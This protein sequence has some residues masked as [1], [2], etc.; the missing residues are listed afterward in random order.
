M[1]KP[2]SCGTNSL[3]LSELKI[4]SSPETLIF[5]YRLRVEASERA[6]VGDFEPVLKKSYKLRRER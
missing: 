3:N 5:A 4:R 1:V 2:P 6:G